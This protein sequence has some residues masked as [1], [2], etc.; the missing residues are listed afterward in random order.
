MISKVLG[1]HTLFPESLH[2]MYG[3]GFVHSMLSGE[4]LA[5]FRSILVI[6]FWNNALETDLGEPWLKLNYILLEIL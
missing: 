1:S 2:Q 3:I 5:M 4:H 6:I